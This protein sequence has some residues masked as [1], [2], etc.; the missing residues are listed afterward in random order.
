MILGGL[1]FGLV[2]PPLASTAVGVVPPRRAGMASGSNSTFRQ[3]GIAAGIAMLGTLF[4]NKVRD[5]VLAK[6]TTVPGVRAGQVVGAIQS[7]QIGRVLRQ[8]PPTPAAGRADHPVGLH[9]RPERDPARGGH[10][11]DRRP[12]HLS[13]LD[14]AQG[15]R[16][17]RPH[18][19]RRLSRRQ[20]ASGRGS[21]RR[22]RVS[23][24]TSYPVDVVGAGAAAT[25]RAPAPG[26]CGGC[27]R[28]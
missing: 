5:D 9:H 24:T 10:H 27:R 2:N 16:A 13:D 25:P 28:R 23:D 11:R 12:A 15:L 4:S 22:V 18:P 1:G 17:A 8:L 6:A 21:P 3:M 14:P 20:P 19:G 7:G 26:S